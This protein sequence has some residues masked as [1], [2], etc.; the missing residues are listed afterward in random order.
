MSIANMLDVLTGV[1]TTN[2]HTDTSDF[3]TLCLIFFVKVF[4]KSLFL[5]NIMYSMKTGFWLFL[6]HFTEFMNKCATFFVVMSTN[7]L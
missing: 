1:S 4:A 2:G 6:S 7:T 5:Y 3:H